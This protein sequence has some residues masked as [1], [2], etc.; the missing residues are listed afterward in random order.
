MLNGEVSHDQAT[1][2][3]SER[4]YTSKDLWRQ[5]KPTARQLEREAG[6]LISDDTIQE[7]AWKDE[8]EIMCW[9]YDHGKRQAVKGINLL[10][11][12]Y[13]NGEVSVP[14]VFE[15]IRKPV[16]FCDVITRQVKRA[17]VVT[18]KRADAGDAE[19]LCAGRDKIPLCGD[20]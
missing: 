8:N 17:S 3:L 15:V 20:G 16:Q 7:K 12:L 10:N 13:H 2:F 6:C 9:H 11:A 1:R 18:K 14:V 19:Y 4:N 5:V